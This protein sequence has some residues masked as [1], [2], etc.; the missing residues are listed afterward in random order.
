[1]NPTQPSGQTDT[2]ANEPSDRTPEGAQFPG[3]WQHTFDVPKEIPLNTDFLVSIKVTATLF[4]VEDLEIVPAA[5]GSLKCVKGPSWKGSLKKGE[6]RDMALT[7]RA[8]KPG[9]NGAYGL[10]V[11]APKFY[12]EVLAYV[13]AQQSGPY[14][15]QESKDSIAEQVGAMRQ[16]QP[17]HEEWVG[18]SITVTE[19][20]EVKK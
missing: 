9:F 16:S 15:T 17:L 2:S 4:D 8:T 18:S 1:M 7:L 6:T 12:D 11:K 3:C 10:I 19:R 14:A 5:S 20:G 13:N